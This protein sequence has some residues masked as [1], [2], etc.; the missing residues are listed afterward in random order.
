[1]AI[2]VWVC[3][4]LAFRSRPM[5][6]KL[7]AQLDRYQQ[8][9]E[10]LRR[11]AMFGIPILLGIFAGVA[12]SSRW[13]LA[14]EWINQTQTGI[15]DPQF[16]L[17][18]A[19]Y[20]FNL[21]FYQSVLAFASAVILLSALATLATSYLYGSLRLNGR[22][23]RIAKAARIQ[24]AVIGAVYLAVQAVS[25]WLDQ[26]ATMATSSTTDLLVGASNADVSAL[27]PGRQILSGAAAIVAVL[28]IITAF[29]GRWRF[30]I[31]GTA[32][33]L[34]MGLLIGSVYPWFVQ[35]FQ[36]EPSAKTAEA[37]YI[38]RNIDAT[39]DAY[40]VSSVKE[41]PYTAATDN[42]AGRAAE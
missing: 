10:P 26:Y 42:R 5:Y 4:Q 6:A 12:T 33:L 23:L 37:P 1:M 14:L 24:L 22:E 8:V 34:V 21:P 35:K 19:F 30:P 39:R 16:H 17:D 31:I 29:I 25:I 38:Q 9:I 20:L 7:N 11:V 2:P 3:L 41:T 13:P 27:I 32:L 36:V 18:V 40:G 28:F 15:N